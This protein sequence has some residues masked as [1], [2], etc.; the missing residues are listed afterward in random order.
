[1]EEKIFQDIMYNTVDIDQFKETVLGLGDISGLP[2]Q[3]NILTTVFKRKSIVGLTEMVF[4]LFTFSLTI[5]TTT[6]RLG[7]RI[8]CPG[9]NICTHPGCNR[10]ATFVLDVNKNL[11]PP[12]NLLW[13]Q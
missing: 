12:L 10:K 5:F 6:Y 11:P 9:D 2:Q 1:M 3:I 8:A 4:F 7:A 13:I